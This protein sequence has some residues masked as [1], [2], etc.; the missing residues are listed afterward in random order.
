MK[1]KSLL[2]TALLLLTLM[3]TACDDAGKTRVETGK[4]GRSEADVI[5]SKVTESA[6][7]DS[8]EENGNNKQE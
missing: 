8:K 5:E 4:T 6:K 1:K 7:K 2:I 3:L